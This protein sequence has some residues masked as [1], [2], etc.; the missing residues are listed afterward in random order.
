MRDCCSSGTSA[1]GRLQRRELE[2]CVGAAARQARGVEQTRGVFWT[3]W[4]KDSRG[5]VVNA[6]ALR[7][8]DGMGEGGCGRCC[9]AANGRMGVEGAA[10]CA[11]VDERLVDA[12]AKQD[13]AWWTPGE[14][15]GDDVGVPV[16]AATPSGSSGM[17]RA[18]NSEVKTR[19]HGCT[20][21][22]GTITAAS[23]RQAGV[24]Q[25]GAA[26]VAVHRWRC[27]WAARKPSGGP[28]RQGARATS[29]RTCDGIFHVSD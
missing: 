8:R 18:T 12:Q 9:N 23:A 21:L 6:A 10:H 29:H 4:R 17:R 27:D 15:N 1:A 26:A 19:V 3:L 22:D 7:Q 13:L 25:R 16:G 28:Q 14:R 5:E 24:R 20:R 11:V 2:R